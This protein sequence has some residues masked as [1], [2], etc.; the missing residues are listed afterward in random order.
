MNSN[1][2]LK[3]KLGIVV[4][5]VTILGAA[6]FAEDRWNQE[7]E[8]RAAESQIEQVGQQTVNTLKQFQ[9]HQDIKFELQRQQW[10]NDMIIKNKMELRKYPNEPDLLEQKQELKDERKRIKEKLEKLME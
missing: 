2:K 4:A 9:K 10:I 7:S 3:T 5:S 1:N 6:Y 8:L